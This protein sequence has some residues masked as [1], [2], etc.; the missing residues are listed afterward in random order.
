MPGTTTFPTT[1]DTFPAIGPSTQEDAV[2]VE[3][4]VV[5]E[6]VHAAVKALEEKVGVDSSSD[7][8]SIDFKVSAALALAAASIPSAVAGAANG[9]ATLD[10]AGKVPKSQLPPGSSAS[11]A[12][13]FA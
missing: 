1:I 13:F 7:V 3:H 2:G 8:D 5:H 6:N 4:D 11:G 10:S 12:V 9:V